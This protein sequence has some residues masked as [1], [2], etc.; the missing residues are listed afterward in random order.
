MLSEDFRKIGTIFICKN[1]APQTSKET[2]KIICKWLR[3]P[4]L[5]RWNSKFL[6]VSL[7][8]YAI[9]S[10]EQFSL[11][12]GIGLILGQ[13]VLVVGV[14]WMAF[15]QKLRNW[16]LTGVYE[17]TAISIGFF[18]I[19]GSIIWSLIYS[20]IY[21]LP[22][23]QFCWYQ[24]MALYPQA[25]ILGVALWKGAYKSAIASAIILNIIGLG[26]ALYHYSLNMEKLLYPETVFAPC[27]ASGI[28]CADIPVLIFGYMTI[29]FMTIVVTLLMIGILLI[30]TYSTRTKN[31]NV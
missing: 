15:S 10:L 5:W 22:I 9:M 8:S 11:L 7:T 6:R 23:C 24:R 26:I 2:R 20:T 27:D 19:L 29:P 4:F 30:A 1:L 18:I 3:A 21:E 12:T 14:F 31:T 25:I 28:S 13:I 16:I 17:K